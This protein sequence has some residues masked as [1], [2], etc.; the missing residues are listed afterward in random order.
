MELE[1]CR[2]VIDSIDEQIVTLLNRRAAE[3]RKI[4]RLKAN[5]GVP[6][7]D[8]DREKEVFKRIIAE[9]NGYIPEASLLRIYA[10]IIRESRKLQEAL[11]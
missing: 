6:P 9:N 11:Q 7:V 2:K 8:L 5:N 4:A 10:R 1:E 3:V